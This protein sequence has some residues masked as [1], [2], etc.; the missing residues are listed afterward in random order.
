[1]T[2]RP[3]AV[4]RMWTS[5][6]QLQGREFCFI[7]NEAV[8]GDDKVWA[9]PA[10]GLTRAVN[11]L[12]VT[13]GRAAPAYP[14]NDECFRGGGFDDQSIS[15]DSSSSRGVLFASQRFWP[16]R[17]RGRRLTHLFSARRPR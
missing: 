4:Q 9:G 15:T 2:C 8:R 11:Q 12:C 1:M 5:Y 6:K 13:Y 10:A 17:S 3:E 14:P 7:L 16:P